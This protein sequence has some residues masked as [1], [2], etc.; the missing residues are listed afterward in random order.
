[1]RAQSDDHQVPSATGE[2][3][4]GVAGDFASERVLPADTHVREGSGADAGHRR[5]LRGVSVSRGAAAV[6]DPRPRRPS[7]DEAYFTQRNLKH[8]A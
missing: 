7:P 3:T 6:Q 8:A 4:G 1:M 2:A 5:T